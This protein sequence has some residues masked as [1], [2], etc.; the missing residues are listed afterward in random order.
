MQVCKT[1]NINL[2]IEMKERERERERERINDSLIS[3]HYEENHRNHSSD[4][5]HNDD[6]THMDKRRKNLSCR[7]TDCEVGV[8]Q[9]A[10][11]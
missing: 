11:P 10:Q 4:R 9:A 7:A 2:K 5:E 6:S 1:S 3:Y 8:S